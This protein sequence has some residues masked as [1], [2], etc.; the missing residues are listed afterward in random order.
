MR[1]IAVSPTHVHDRAADL[2]GA[3]ITRELRLN[4]ARFRKG[5]RI[6][7]GDLP[8]LALSELPV[9]AV[10][11]DDDDVHEDE[12]ARRLAELIRGDGVMQ[13][14][15][16]QSRVNLVSTRKG[17]LQVD[18]DAL[19]RLNLR[20]DLGIFTAPDHLPVVTGKIVAG[21]KIAPVAVPQEV[22][23]DVAFEIGA[24]P[25]PV[26]Q[27]LPFRPLV[28]GVVVTEGKV[29]RIRDRF[30]A[31]VRQKM[32]WYGGSILRFMYVADDLDEVAAAM[33]SLLNDGATLLL[34]AGGH[35]MDPLDAMQR[36][37]D[38]VGGRI[39][40]HGAPAHPG[41]M[42]WLGHLDRLDVPI[43]SLA[44]CSMFSRSTVAD[45]VLPRVFAGERVTSED[46]AV[47]GHGGLL[48]RDM[49]WRF[50]P[51]DVETVDEPDEA[52]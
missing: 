1:P 25:R 29:D 42:F 52:E 27:V 21:A 41:S 9:H 32:G 2:T 10:V 23:E 43:V 35:M 28:A 20:P 19:L 15:P 37:V 18:T 22:L 30:E 16:V 44:S 5:Q 8:T 36:A 40:R 38:L 34:A 6:T 26:V 51:Y 13:R 46:L 50:P 3:V 48:D 31:S 45:L 24:N 7:K 12:A 11:L 39:V 47:L 14:D 4:G 17:L 33:R 49:A